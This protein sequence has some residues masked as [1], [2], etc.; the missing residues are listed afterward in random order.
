M[1]SQRLDPYA[2][3]DELPL[4]VSR[5]VCAAKVGLSLRTIDR[6][7]AAG[8]LRSVRIGG[9]RLIVRASIRPWLLAGL[10]RVE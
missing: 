6:A 9:R 8:A 5:S 10:E 4:N 2:E 7:L 1:A 3:L